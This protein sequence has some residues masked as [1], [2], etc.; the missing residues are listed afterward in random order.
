SRCPWFQGFNPCFEILLAYYGFCN[1]VTNC[2]PRFQRNFAELERAIYII[3]RAN[4]RQSC[5]DLRDGILQPQWHQTNESL[6]L[7]GVSMTGV[8][9]ASW[10]SDYQI[11]RLRNAAV[12]GAYSQADEWHRPRPKA[13]TTMK[14]EGTGSKAM[15][16][17]VLGE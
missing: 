12:L 4:Y 11:R 15:G 10:L 3:A 9:Q 5:V 8:A 7:C 17:N 1:L 14:P 2:L 6:H 13:I 16:S